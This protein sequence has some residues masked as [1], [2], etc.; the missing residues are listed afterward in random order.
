MT[1]KVYKMGI[2]TSSTDVLH[3]L[4]TT[5]QRQLQATTTNHQPPT[6]HTSTHPHPYQP[7][8]Q[9]QTQHQHGHGMSP[10]SIPSL[11]PI[12]Y[13]PTPFRRQWLTYL[14]DISNTT[15]RPRLDAQIHA[16]RGL[17]LGR[18]HGHHGL[19]REFH[20]LSSEPGE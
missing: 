3:Q 18:Y 10:I 20:A 12:F 6:T 17:P 9:P 13:R 8:E 11:S 4:T 5:I 16:T 1:S 19:W 15:H 2:L 14:T 7:V